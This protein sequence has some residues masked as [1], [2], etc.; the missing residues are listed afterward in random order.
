MK[1]ISA[2]RNFLAV[3]INVVS[4]LILIR[5][6]V[7]GE[8]VGEGWRKREGEVLFPS[9]PTFG[10]RGYHLYPTLR[11]RSSL[12]FLPGEGNLS[13]KVSLSELLQYFPVQTAPFDNSL[14][15]NMLW[16]QNKVDKNISGMQAIFSQ[17]FFLATRT[18]S[19]RVSGHM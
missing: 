14:L 2:T 15:V 5:A 11:D 1:P 4:G 13:H 9:L 6:W 19:F 8:G 16:F 18:F 7:N 12:L 10:R 3:Q 17:T